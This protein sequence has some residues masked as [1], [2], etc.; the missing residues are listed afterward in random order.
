MPS[1]EEKDLFSKMIDE[2]AARLGITI[3]DSVIEYC[4]K[5]G[6]EIEVAATLL[7]PTL[8]SNIEMDAMDLHFLPK[9]SRLPL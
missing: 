3:M 8:K 2:Q 7:S 5:S 9:K 6:M 4:S 1:K